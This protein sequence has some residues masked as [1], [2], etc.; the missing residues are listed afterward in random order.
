[1]Y[2]AFETKAALLD[3]V[4]DAAISDARGSVSHAGSDRPSPAG[5]PREL[6]DFAHFAA[7]VMDRA[8]RVLAIAEAAA[9]VDP[10]LARFREPGHRAMQTR[11][12]A[13]AASLDSAGALAPGITA[14]EAAATIYA[15]V[16]ET[17]YLR[18]IDGYGWN[19]QR[20]AEWLE[21]TLTTALLHNPLKQNPNRT[22][23]RDAR[24]R[25]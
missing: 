2:L 18:L 10:E 11:F 1:V 21:H 3:A 15:I 6:R 20:Y 12:E 23:R 8:A 22:R 17:V 13:I 24:K 16:N 9:T 4:I 25:S 14:K 5:S 7:R 19:T